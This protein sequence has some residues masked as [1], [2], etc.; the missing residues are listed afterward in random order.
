LTTEL[1]FPTRAEGLSPRQR[2]IQPVTNRQLIAIIGA[3]GGAGRTT[4]TRLL[5][6]TAAWLRPAEGSAIAVDTVPVCGRLTSDAWEKGAMNILTAPRIRWADYGWTENLSRSVGA[7]TMPGP[8]PEL[9]EF[10]TSSTAIDAIQFLMDKTDLIIAD[11]ANDLG[12]HIVDVLVR[13]AA[14]VVVVANEP[15]QAV[16]VADYF[17]AR[18]TP[19][20]G[21]SIAVL[22][23]QPRRWWQRRPVAPRLTPEFEETI[24]IPHVRKYDESRP[25]PALTNAGVALLAAVIDRA[26]GPTNG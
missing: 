9:G 11:T 8:D 14:V 7:L 3:Q 25:T 6:R 15:W 24:V 16:Q 22:R 17:T 5:T 1:S 12:T 19:F 2:A 21:R 13:H 18:S 26:N 4:V 10:T 23:G 20:T